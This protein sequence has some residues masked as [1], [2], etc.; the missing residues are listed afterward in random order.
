MTN[1]KL[2]KFESDILQLFFNLCPQWKQVITQQIQQSTFW[3]E[4]STSNHSVCFMNDVN[5][6]RLNITTKMPV[7]IILGKVDIPAES[8]INHIKG[9]DVI[10]PCILSG[11]DRDAIGA[12]MYFSDG[13]LTELEIYSIS[14]Q[15]LCEDLEIKQQCTYIVHTECDI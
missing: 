7:E 12:R 4:R 2:T 13:L 3:R 14:G 15:E 11:L 6:S 10:S 5:V 9:C 8:R 1:L